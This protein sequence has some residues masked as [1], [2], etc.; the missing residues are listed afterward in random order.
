MILIPNFYQEEP[1]LRTVMRSEFQKKGYT[2]KEKRLILHRVLGYI[3]NMKEMTDQ[4]KEKVI[5]FLR[6]NNTL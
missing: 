5:A 1:S 6:V 2:I 4:E 3:P